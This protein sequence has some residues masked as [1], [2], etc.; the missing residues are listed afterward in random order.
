MKRKILKILVWSVLCLVMLVIAGLVLVQYFFPSERVRQELQALLS[1]RVNATVTIQSLDFDVFRGLQIKNVDVLK[2]QDRLAHLESLAL[3]YNLWHL[4]HGELVINELVLEGA[5]VSLNLEELEREAEKEPAPVAGE[6]PEQPSELP[7]VPVM[8]D[9]QT[10]SIRD[11]NF[12]VQ[13]GKDFSVALQDVD[14][15]AS[16]AAGPITADL[17]GVLNVAMLE[18]QVQGRRLR[19][20]LAVEFELSVNVP[21]RSVV[22]KQ[23]M[24]RSDPVVRMALS[25]QVEEV[26]TT[27]AINATVTDLTVDLEQ[28]SRVAADFIPPELA[29]A[30]IKGN[31]VHT[32]TVKGRFL[33]SGFAGVAR[34]EIESAD[35]Q[36][37]FPSLDMVLEPMSVALRCKS[38]G[39]IPLEGKLDVFNLP[40][41]VSCH[42]ELRDV[43]GAFQGNQVDGASGTIEVV[44]EP[45]KQNRV[46]ITAHLHVKSL[47][48]SEDLP[49][50]KASNVAAEVDV[51]AEEFDQLTVRAMR[52]T[53]DGAEF[54]IQGD[55][56]GVRGLL[57]NPGSRLG[58]H[59]GPLFVKL[60]GRADVDVKKFPDL[61]Q[62]Y[63]LQGSGRGQ[64]ALSVLKKKN[65]P[66]EVQVRL[67]PKAIS[68]TKDATKVINAAGRVNIQK[69][70][71][72][73]PGQDAARSRTALNARP[74]QAARTANASPQPDLTIEKMVIGSLR[75]SDFAGRLEVNRDQLLAQNLA[76]KLLGGRVEG[77]I[78]LTGG[79]S[80]IAKTK[81]E[82]AQLDLNEL[83]P[84]D[85]KV[86]GD[87]R[88]DGSV[89]IAASLDD[90]GEIDFSRTQ[91]DLYLARI[92]RNALMQL[93]Q[94][95]DPERSDPTI[96]GVLLALQFAN[97]ADARIALSKGMLDVHIR[98]RGGLLA[99]PL[100]LQRVPIDRIAFFQ[101][102]TK[103]IPE[104][105][106]IRHTMR[107]LGADQYGVDQAGSMYLR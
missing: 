55:A 1:E 14:L 65:G 42:A 38:V 95:I 36:G 25:G 72:W 10:F 66:L 19:L 52:V 79:E 49:L 57:E 30:R 71:E 48:L 107:L 23:V 87:S 18:T 13:T 6:Q 21:T 35:L 47:Q 50:R 99:S 86:Q 27:R 37:I 29:G 73:I 61:L 90:K 2:R 93:L 92:G 39:T 81:L 22:V 17:S 88:V 70:L 24:L 97:P 106:T 60:Q 46:G 45:E 98:F 3:E 77:W 32:F 74:I 16:L 43:H 80:F 82:F 67:D 5:D 62:T 94:S 4:L 31:L 69:S 64:L 15:E 96:V 91:V 9:L 100:K 40:I 83:L 58:Q 102:V 8:L 54:S 44:F 101:N 33:D 85:R 68:I 59:L 26:L 84:P 89:D 103:N 34:A 28:L 63:G 53:L 56:A 76:M 7:L 105:E 78:E 20:P 11:S 12:S 104:W 75:I 51:T 41:G